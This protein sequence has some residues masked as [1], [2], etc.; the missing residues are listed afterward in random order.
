MNQ[1][2]EETRYSHSQNASPL[3]ILLLVGSLSLV[4]LLPIVMGGAARAATGWV[5]LGITA[6]L[7]FG[8]LL[9]FGRLQIH[10]TATE[11]KWHFGFGLPKFSLPLSEITS[12]RIVASPRLY[13][14]GIRVIPNG[15]LFNVS[16]TKGVELV[17]ANRQVV[18]LGTD[19]PEALLAAIESARNPSLMRGHHP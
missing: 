8:T 10:I 11:V 14:Y 16:G 9:V 4:I 18:R 1:P 6:V 12:A 7:L 19:E 13:G 17:K 15:M 5:P 2:V 3:M